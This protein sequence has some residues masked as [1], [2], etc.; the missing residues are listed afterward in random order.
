MNAMG[1]PV[2]MGAVVATVFVDRP[3]TV[4]DVVVILST[5]G[6]FGKRLFIIANRIFAAV[7]AVPD[8]KNSNCAQIDRSPVC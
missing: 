2:A 3:T 5:V 7:S 6:E 8:L 1:S 4:G